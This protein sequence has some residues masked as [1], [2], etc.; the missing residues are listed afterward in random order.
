MAELVL[1]ADGAPG[2]WLLAEA[3]PRYHE[4]PSS[5][6]FSFAESLG[7]SVQRLWGD[8]AVLAVDIPIGLSA[9]GHRPADTLARERLG[10]RR[11]TFFPTPIR[12]VLDFDE[13][14]DANAHSKTTTGA[15]LSKQA[16]NLI[17]KI[18]H[19]DSLWS[20]DLSTQLL[21]AHPETSFAELNEAPVMA[22]KASAEGRGERIALL[23]TVYGDELE[24]ALDDLPRRLW[25]D[26][27][28]AAAIAWTARRVVDGRAIILGGELDAAG[29]PM[30][31]A[32]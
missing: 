29:R 25:V 7:P 14:T 1:G 13:Y 2:G 11:S 6:T 5:V 30:Q 28:D 26:A 19:V 9:D 21:E 22:K 20:Q 3:S 31:L 4:G 10:P 16:W 17:P 8:V 15:G 24:R 12:S 23:K 18:R 32:I 27:I